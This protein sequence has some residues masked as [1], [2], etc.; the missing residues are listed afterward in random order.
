MSRLH[1]RI[2]FLSLAVVLVVGLATSL[3]FVLGAGH[4]F[5]HEQND[6]VARHLASLVAASV[7]DR[8]E[9]GRRVAELR[10]ELGVGMIVRDRDGRVIAETSRWRRGAWRSTAPV[11]DPRSGEVIGTLELIG[12]RPFVGAWP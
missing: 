7:N 9:L 4:S 5:F 11:R 8:R 1:S 6:R 2:Y 10:E 12:P 3:V